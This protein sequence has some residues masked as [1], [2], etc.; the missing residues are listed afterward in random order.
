MHT[1]RRTAEYTF[2]PMTR[3]PCR[4]GKLR[5]TLHNQASFEYWLLMLRL[6]HSAKLCR[7]AGGEL[8]QIQM[9]LGH[10]SVQTTERYLGIKQDL[11]HAPNDAIQLKVERDSG[12]KRTPP[13]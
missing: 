2:Q 1:M 5:R 9:L 6:R 3:W 13:G 7:A 4:T 12:R 11:I 10:A 8:E